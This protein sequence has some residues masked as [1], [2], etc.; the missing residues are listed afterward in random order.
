M[1]QRVVTEQDFR[2]PEYRTAKPEDYE[3]REDGKVVRKDRW[4]MA[5]QSIRIAVGLDTREFEIDD[6]VAKV[7]ALADADGNW[8]EYDNDDDEMPERIDVQ[9]ADGSI[10]VNLWFEAGVLLWN[11][12]VKIPIPR[13]DVRAWRDHQEMPAKV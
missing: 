5:V 12:D 6:V 11:P 10:L 9:L 3:F 8:M 1:S 13:E 2:M 4:E 7:R